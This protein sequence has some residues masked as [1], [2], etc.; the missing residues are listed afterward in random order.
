MPGIIGLLRVKVTVDKEPPKKPL[1]AT[2]PATEKSQIRTF[3]RRRSCACLA[4]VSQVSVL[5]PYAKLQFWALHIFRD[6]TCAEVSDTW[7]VTHPA[8]SVRDSI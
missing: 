8:S 4:G 2:G 5:F 6:V 3:L 7:F 1:M